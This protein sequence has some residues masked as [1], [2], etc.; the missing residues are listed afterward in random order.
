[1][2]RLVLLGP[3]GAG[4]GTYG[5][6]LSEKYQIPSISTGK[7]FRKEIKD[8]TAIGE[9]AK[10]YIDKGELVPDDIVLDMMLVRLSAEDCKNGFL[11]DGFPRTVFQAEELD[12]YLNNMGVAIDKAIDIYVPEDVLLA[13]MV[14]RRV[15]KVCGATYHVENLPPKKEGVC[16]VCGG[17][18]YQRDDDAQETVKHRFQV[19]YKQ[20]LPLFKYYE[21]AGTLVRIEGNGGLEHVFKSIVSKLGA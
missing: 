8:G 16:D 6:K 5:S 11:L 21:D 19:Y 12:K 15:C 1:L 7:I 2:F 20:T 4:K 18:V 13:R 10:E 9:K 14:G 3:P 17:E